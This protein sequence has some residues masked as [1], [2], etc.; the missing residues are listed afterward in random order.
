MIAPNVANI[1]FYNDTQNKNIALFQKFKIFDHNHCPLFLLYATFFCDNFAVIIFTLLICR[2]KSEN[3]EI[4]HKAM[5]VYLK[6]DTTMTILNCGAV[7][8]YNK[9]QLCSAGDQVMGMMPWVSDE[10]SCVFP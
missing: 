3:T 7:T 2:I 5:R 4:L 10:T 6:E 9:D 1:T 8:C